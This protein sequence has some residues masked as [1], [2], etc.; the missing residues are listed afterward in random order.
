MERSILVERKVRAHPVVVGHVI[1]QQ[2]TE[3]PF[4]QD[5][6]V[7][8]ALASDRADQPFDMPRRACEDRR[9][10]GQ[11]SSRA[12]K[13]RQKQQRRFTNRPGAAAEGTAHPRIRLYSQEPAPAGSAY[14]RALPI[15]AAAKQ[16]ADAVPEPAEKTLPVLDRW[17]ELIRKLN[18]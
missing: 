12:N 16:P 3:V 13:Q 5:H 9:W 4:P 1:R 10:V 11:V 14:C 2:M 7:V 18:A 17:A 15:R 8:E 6:N